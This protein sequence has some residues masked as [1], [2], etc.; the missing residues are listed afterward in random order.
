MKVN[1]KRTVGAMVIAMVY[2]TFCGITGK[3]IGKKLGD[4]II[5]EA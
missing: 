2:M 1:K 3:L 4:W 5:E